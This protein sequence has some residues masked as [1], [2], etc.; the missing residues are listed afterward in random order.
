MQSVTSAAQDHGPWH[1][2]ERRKGGNSAGQVA[3]F[4]G[5]VAVTKLPVAPCTVVL[6]KAEAL[7]QGQ[8]GISA[9]FPKDNADAG[10]HHAFFADAWKLNMDLNVLKTA[11]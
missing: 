6:S 8:G 11:I 3:P 1:P 9:S 4:L 5:H 10:K 2:K 7:V